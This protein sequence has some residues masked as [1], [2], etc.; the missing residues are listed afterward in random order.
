MNQRDLF[1]SATGHSE[2]RGVIMHEDSEEL[3][4]LG[5]VSSSVRARARCGR[6]ARR[7]SCPSPSP[8]VVSNWQENYTWE[9]RTDTHYQP[10]VNRIVW[11]RM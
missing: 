2:L 3:R 11:R 4:M 10:C 1:L 9:Y 6:G 5:G 8:E 7:C